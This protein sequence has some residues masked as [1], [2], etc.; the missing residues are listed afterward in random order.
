[1]NGPAFSSIV[2]SWTPQYSSGDGVETPKTEL[3]GVRLT[4]IDGHCEVRRGGQLIR[5]GTYS[6]DTTTEPKSIDVCFAESDVP[7]L[8][9]APLLGIFELNDDR[10]RI[11]YGAPGGRRA[12]S[13]SGD[14]GT[15]QYLAEYVRSNRKG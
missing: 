7:E 6:V 8:V 15:Q 12:L 9:G 14:E 5:L 13:F 3:D 2:G 1:M 11:C 10:L 4:F